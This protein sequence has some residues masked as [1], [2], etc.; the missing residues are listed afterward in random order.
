[1]RGGSTGRKWGPG[2]NALPEPFETPGRDPTNNMSKSG[3]WQGAE[4]G[5]KQKRETEKQEGIRG[6]TGAGQAA[7]KI[8]IGYRFKTITEVIYSDYP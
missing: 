7:R 5:T 3:V 6:G 4:K 1:M 2:K 8:K